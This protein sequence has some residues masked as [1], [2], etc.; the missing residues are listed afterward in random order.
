MSKI[1]KLIKI[2]IRAKIIWKKPKRKNILIYDYEGSNKLTQYFK[3]DSFHILCVRKEEL[4]FYILMKKF[5]LLLIK[6]DFKIYID[7]YINEVRPKLIITFI[8]NEVFVEYFLSKN[9]IVFWIISF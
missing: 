1:L 2:I 3:T 4:N 7:E 8:D 6:Q 5:F 9:F